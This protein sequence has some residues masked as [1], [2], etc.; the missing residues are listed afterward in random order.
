MINSDDIRVGNQV[1]FNT[2]GLPVTILK[3][4]ENK[5][6]LNTFPKSS[7]YS[8]HDISGIP[9][10]TS[11][12]RK[13]S[14]SNEEEH[15]KWFGQGVNIHTKPDGFYYGLRISKSRAKIQY[16]H[17]LQNYVTD[18]YALFRGRDYCL[19][20]STLENEAKII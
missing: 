16:L 7:Y 9:L 14:F 12:L 18:F 19:D 8:N 4:E 6:L 3:V 11:V 17:E 13:L 2:S 20:I 1:L 5:V 15:T 10:T